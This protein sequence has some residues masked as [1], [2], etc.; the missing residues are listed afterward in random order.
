[1]RPRL[2]RCGVAAVLVVLS[3]CTGPKPTPQP[4]GSPSPG[5][6]LSPDTPL[7]FGRQLPAACAA[8]EPTDKQNV[9]F[10]MLGRIWALDPN[11]GQLSCLMTAPDPGPFLWGPQGNR[12]I[13]AGFQIAGWSSSPSFAATGLE[14]A[15]EGWSR[16]RGTAII[17]AKKNATRPEMFFTE[18][19]HTKTMTLLPAATYLDFAY[20]PTGLAIGYILE[21]N[22]KQEIWFSMNTGL[23]A[24]RL[25][26]SEIGTTFSDLTFSRDG[27]FLYYVA[28]HAQ[29]YSEMHFIDLRFPKTLVSIWKSRKGEYVG[30]F[31]LSPNENRIAVTEGRACG[32]DKAALLGGTDQRRGTERTLLPEVTGPTTTLGWLDNAT[33][34]VGAGGCDGAPVDLYAVHANGN[35][36]PVLLVKGAATGTVRPSRPSWPTALPQEVKLVA[37]SG[38]G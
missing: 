20:H 7:A 5:P 8:T 30:T 22:G 24:K 14:P 19:G 16:P 26:F 27:T 11:S 28:H 13:L 29:G 6:T 25:V 17:L 32:Q 18:T 38:V 1:M 23:K 35:S 4:S 31:A 2:V 36:S 12:V 33:V 21:R 10:A 34:L 15:A 3:A 9:V 37:G